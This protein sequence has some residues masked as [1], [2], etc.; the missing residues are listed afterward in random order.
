ML[1]NIVSYITASRAEWVS[2]VEIQAVYPQAEAL[3]NFTVFNVK[4]NKYRLIVSVNYA[5][6]VVYIRYVR[7][8]CKQIDSVRRVQSQF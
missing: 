2:L 6:Q 4:G 7:I 3:G 1:P 8:F 5:K